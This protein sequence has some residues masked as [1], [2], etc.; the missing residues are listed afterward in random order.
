MSQNIEINIKN[1][2]GYEVLYPNII[3]N[4]VVDFSGDNP[5]LSDSTK[6]L[7]GLGTNA[8]PDDVFNL[9][10]SNGEY[11]WK[12]RTSK[13]IEIISSNSLEKIRM[14]DSSNSSS[15][16]SI[17]YSSIINLD[18][19]NRI[20]LVNQQSTGFGSYDNYTVFNILIGK[21]AK[22]YSVETSV[23]AIFK[24]PNGQTIQREIYQVSGYNYYRVY[25]YGYKQS[26][27]ITEA[28][29]WEYLKSTNRNAYPDKG[30]SGG[31]DYEYIGV[32]F[33]NLPKSLKIETGSYIGSGLYGYGNPNTLQLS[34]VPSIL[35]IYGMVA[36]GN[37]SGQ[38]SFI[39]M[40]E[41]D[42]Y[43]YGLTDGSFTGGNII[44]WN[45]EISWFENPSDS[46][47]LYAE[48]QLNRAGDIYKYVAIG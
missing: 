26:V 42:T 40:V 6:S 23:E 16:A 13:K 9:L 7:F 10:S 29:E 17:N 4:N 38:T 22:V 35:I 5:L 19:F 1:E 33:N 39:V 31:Y 14:T 12:R 32:P 36:V 24:I 18:P 41:G 27:K 15:F 47:S 11:W 34:F 44:K 48:A 21:Y 43:S 2:S 45:T 28:G 30:E 20:Q 3:A 46:V 37:R 8:V 25:T